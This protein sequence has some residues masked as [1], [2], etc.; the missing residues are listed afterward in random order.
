MEEWVDEL[1]RSSVVAFQEK[2]TR[3]WLDKADLLLLL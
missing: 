2:W 1:V 3:I